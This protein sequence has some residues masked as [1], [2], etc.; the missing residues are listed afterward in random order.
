MVVYASGS[1][2]ISF[3]KS[4]II[5]LAIASH[6]GATDS[7]T[8]PAV[9]SMVVTTAR[10]S[11]ASKMKRIILIRRRSTRYSCFVVFMILPGGQRHAILG[12]YFL[13]APLVLVLGIII[14]YGAMMQMQYE[15]SQPDQDLVR[16]IQQHLNCHPILATVLANRNIATAQHAADFLQ[17]T[18]QSLPNPMELSGMCKACDRIHQALQK[19]ERIL[20]FGDYD[21]DGVTATAVLATLLKHAGANVLVHLPHRT[22]EGYGL[23]PK[24][25]NQLAIPQKID[26]IVTVDCGS[27]SHEA[28]EAAKRFGIDVIITDHHN[29]ETKPEAY[30]VINP[31]LPQQPESLV[32]LAGVGVAFYLAIGLRMMLREKGWW[33][34]RK[35]PNLSALCDLVAIGTIADVVPLVGVNR[36]LAKTGLQQ[37]NTCPRPGVEALKI[38]SAIR[39]QS[40]NSNDISFRLTPRI[41]AAGRI[42][43]A[44]A[45]YD[46]LT[47]R[48][49]KDAHQIAGALDQLNKQRQAIEHQIYDQIVRQLDSRPDLLERKTLVL[50]NDIWHEGVL[51]IVAAKL[52]TNFHRPVVLVSTRN[53]IGKGSGRSIPGI[54]LFQA[55]DNCRSLLDKFGGHRMAA[56]LTVQYDNIRKLQAAFERAVEQ[57][58]PGKMVE[59]I[60]VDAELRFDQINSQLVTDLERLEPFGEANPAPIFLSKDVQVTSA[61]I[62]G[63]RHRKMILHQYGVNSAPID[64]IQF[65]LKSDEPRADSFEQLIFRLQWNRHNGKRHIQ[66][67]V[68]AV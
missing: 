15:I 30:A 28:I 54:D 58:S 66:I 18:F 37:M 45:A 59:S 17:P 25:M 38:T 60:P 50:A 22:T 34:E 33:K 65:N 53:G 52:A 1:I 7:E 51:G 23:Q 63:G 26:L 6:P 29:I 5:D 36:I 39:S 47:A 11:Y 16:N 61:A 24:H 9:G 55:L 42:A 41:N 64:A 68:E 62:V 32:N 35:E 56:G 2:R 67:M 27:S 43:H 4:S 31:K 44:Q 14:G 19:N 10:P 13:P 21:A 48:S 12:N 49:L 3:A 57:L 40:I 8:T 20:V 46:L